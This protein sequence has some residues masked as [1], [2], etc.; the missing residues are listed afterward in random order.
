MVLRT[1]FHNS[2]VYGRVYSNMLY[3]TLDHESESRGSVRPYKLVMG[4]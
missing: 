2:S 1:E 3:E 4:V